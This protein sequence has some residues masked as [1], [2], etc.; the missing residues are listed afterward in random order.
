MSQRRP[1]VESAAPRI[2]PPLTDLNRPFWSGGATGDLMIQR[3]AD[4]RRWTHPESAGCPTC[5]GALAHEPVAGT[6][7]I[8]TFTV[9]HQ[10]FH[11]D[12]PPPYVIAIVELDDQ[13]ELRIATNIVHCD[14]ATL[15]CGT[16]VQVVFERHGE[17]FVPL[18]EPVG[19]P[20]GAPVSA[21]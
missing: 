6:G 11:P 5:G 1:P 9:N 8:F 16:P 14:P 2:L 18:F 17:V 4:C 10:P 7:R 19:E 15:E 3:C 13:P 12:V 21:D 20:G